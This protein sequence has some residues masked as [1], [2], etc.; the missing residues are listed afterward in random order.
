MKLLVS[1]MLSHL[2]TPENKTLRAL[3]DVFVGSR[4]I[5][6]DLRKGYLGKFVLDVPGLLPG[7]AEVDLSTEGPSF[8]NDA[9]VAYYSSSADPAT[10]NP[11]DLDFDDLD[12]SAGAE[13]G[14]GYEPRNRP[15]RPPHVIIP[16]VAAEGE[17]ADES[18]TKEGSFQ[19]DQDT[20]KG[21]SIGPD[22]DQLETSTFDGW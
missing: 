5:L 16:K 15:E 17:V 4:R 13:G 6:D 8:D 2:S 10:K 22:D 1:Y 7:D 18:R 14:A 11:W 3:G 21:P 20:K 19:N 9:G 12:Y